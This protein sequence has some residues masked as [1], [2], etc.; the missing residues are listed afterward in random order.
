MTVKSQ[1]EWLQRL[2][3]FINIKMI[4]DNNFF[5]DSIFFHRSVTQN[6]QGVFLFGW[7]GNVDRVFLNQQQTLQED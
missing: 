7:L 4:R 3:I 2:L 1:N 5:T 6:D